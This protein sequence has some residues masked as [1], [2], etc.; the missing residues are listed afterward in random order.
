MTKVYFCKISEISEQPPPSKSKQKP[1]V[2]GRQRW[3]VIL[4]STST[5]SVTPYLL[6]GFTT[7]AEQTKS[8]SRAT[9]SKQTISKECAT[10]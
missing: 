4:V 6:A 3:R 8:T 10:H 2:I 1:K 9:S 7:I 5:V